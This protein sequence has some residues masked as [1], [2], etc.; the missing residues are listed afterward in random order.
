MFAGALQLHCVCI[1]SVP[2]DH[3]TV[4]CTPPPFE[5]R[6]EIISLERRHFSGWLKKSCNLQMSSNAN[7]VSPRHFSVIFN[8]ALNNF[9]FYTWYKAGSPVSALHTNRTLL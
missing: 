7:I 2:V 5:E 9:S 1:I 6:G 4:V 8:A 3:M